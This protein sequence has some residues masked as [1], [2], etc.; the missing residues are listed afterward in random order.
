MGACSTAAAS[1]MRYDV[2]HTTEY[3]YSDSVAVAHHVARLRPRTLPAP[4]VPA[5]RADRRPGARDDEHVTRIIS[6][7]A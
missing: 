5:P 2:L 3:D 7:T 6:A 4:G 1:T